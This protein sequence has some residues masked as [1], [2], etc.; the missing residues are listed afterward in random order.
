[1]AEKTM[2]VEVAYALP[3]K[4]KIV[5]LNVPEGTS[6]LDAVRL[7]GMDQ[8]FPELDLE[9]APLGIFGKAVPK[10]AERVLQSGERVEIYRPLIADPKEVRKQRAAKAKAAKTED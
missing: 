1:M 3:H 7:S 2:V 5:T 8:H 6:M 9:S 4:Q 10:P